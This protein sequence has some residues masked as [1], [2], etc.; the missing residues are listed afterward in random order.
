MTTSGEPGETTGASPEEAFA[1]LGNETRLQILLALGEAAGPLA[2]SELYEAV[3]Y[4]TTANFSYH[5]EKLENHFVAATDDGYELQQTGRRVVEAVQSG[6]VTET[7]VLERTPIQTTCFL[8]E[9]SMEVDYRREHVGVYCPD[10][11]GTVGGSSVTAEW[12]SDPGVD[13]VGDVILPPAGVHDRTPGEVLEAAEIWTVTEAQATARGVCPRCSASVEHYAHACDDH[14]ASDE[15]CDR[16]DRQFGATV[17]T[18]CTNCIY[19]E[20]SVFAKYLLANPDVMAFM[21]DHGIDP[22]SPDGFHISALE[23]TILSTDPIEARFS[24][25]AD[26]DALVL[27]VEDLSVVDVSR[28]PAVEQ[29]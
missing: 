28:R 25:T 16:C 6:T 22:I 4:D 14:D 29:K 21:I 9:S 8:C 15:L 1:V 2:F 17:R 23:E 24:F 20:T 19:D 26:G 13:L 7:P 5:L 10:C 12:V 27:Q 11:R 3:D 18:T